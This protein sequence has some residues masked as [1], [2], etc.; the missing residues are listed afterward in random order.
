MLYWIPIW[1]ICSKVSTIKGSTDIRAGSLKLGGAY[2][3]VRAD[4]MVS[5]L[6]HMSHMLKMLFRRTLFYKIV[7]LL[8]KIV[9]LTLLSKFP[10]KGAGQT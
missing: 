6:E 1:I 10:K 5:V 7:A 3:F 2:D 4:N 8:S 9:A